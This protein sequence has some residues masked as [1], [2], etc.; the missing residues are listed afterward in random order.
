M[1]AS[2]KMNLTDF[3]MGDTVRKDLYFCQRLEEQYNDMYM[4]KSKLKK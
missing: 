2:K 1:S 4:G 3:L